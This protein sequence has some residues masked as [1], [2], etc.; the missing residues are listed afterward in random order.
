M[1]PTTA[2]HR[3]NMKPYVDL[4]DRQQLFIDTFLLDGNGAKAAR[5]AGYAAPHHK[6]AYRLKLVLA[7]AITERGYDSVATLMP[8]AIK[9]LGSCLNDRN[10]MVRMKAV[11]QVLGISGIAGIE[12]KEVTITHKTDK[13]IDA[14]LMRLL[15]RNKNTIDVTPEPSDD[16]G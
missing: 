6:A 16:N 15:Q 1:T 2:S 4:D 13:E 9:T 7:H 14:E 11:E 5:V 12:R 10:G 3:P 8:L